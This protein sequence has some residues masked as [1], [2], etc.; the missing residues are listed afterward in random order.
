MFRFEVANSPSQGDSR[1]QCQ[2]ELQLVVR[3]ELHLGQK[4]AQSQANKNTRRVRQGI[5][6][7]PVLRVPR[8]IHTQGE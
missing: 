7:K 5:C 2:T 3:V 4:V 1:E 8:K 6:Q